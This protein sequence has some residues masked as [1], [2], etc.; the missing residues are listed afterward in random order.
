ML[1]KYYTAQYDKDII[2]AASERVQAAANAAGI[3]GHAA[4]LR[5][6][7][8]HSHLDAKYGDAVIIGASSAKQL[9]TNLDIIDAGP[10]PNELA[11][12]VAGIWDD[13]KEETAKYHA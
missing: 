3:T 7:I 10:L 9:E 11:E 8:Y 6:T 1:G 4:A 5:W 2:T 12:V 13:V